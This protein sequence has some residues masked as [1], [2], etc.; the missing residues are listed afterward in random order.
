VVNVISTATAM[1]YAATPSPSARTFFPNVTRTLGGSAGWTTPIIVQSAGAT[2][3][4][5]KWFRFSDGAL[6]TTQVLAITPG[7]AL[8]V[9]PRDVSALSENTQYSVVADGT[10][11]S[12]DG[13]VIELATGGDN[14]M[15][16]EGFSGP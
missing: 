6:V 9:D 14:A 8:R 10:G 2:A 4:T 15:I 13:I 7:S 1:G 3:V 16:Y 12:I 11:G 5:L